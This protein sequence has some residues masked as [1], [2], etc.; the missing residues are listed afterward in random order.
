M[1]GERVLRLTCTGNG[2]GGGLAMLCG[3]LGELAFPNEAR[4]EVVSF[5]TPWVGFNSQFAWVFEQFLSQ[6]LLWPFGVETQV[7]GVSLEEMAQQEL[8]EVENGDPEAVTALADALV[9]TIDSDALKTATHL[10]NLPPAL[11][12]DFTEIIDSEG[13]GLFRALCVSCKERFLLR[14]LCWCLT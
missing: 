12:P 1:S 2:A 5:G 3:L 7:G 10:P 14:L 8:L 11:P 4:V 9:A 6:F 13:S